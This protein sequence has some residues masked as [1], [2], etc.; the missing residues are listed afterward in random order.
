[1]WLNF[2][3]GDADRDPEPTDLKREFLTG[4]EWQWRVWGYGLRHACEQDIA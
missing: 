2:H 1:V 3:R 4:V